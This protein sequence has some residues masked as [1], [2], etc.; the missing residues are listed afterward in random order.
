MVGCQ[1]LVQAVHCSV[2]TRQGCHH[3]WPHCVLLSC[4]GIAV[5]SVIGLSTCWTVMAAYYI[6]YAVYGS[7]MLMLL[8]VLCECIPCYCNITFIVDVIIGLLPTMHTG[9]CKQNW[10]YDLH[11]CSMV[12]E[13]LQYTLS[14]PH[15]TVYDVGENCNCILH[16]SFSTL[17]KDCI[18]QYTCIV[19]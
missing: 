13:P 14:L 6:K 18:F 4:R 2:R 11:I 3:S 15:S 10:L 17:Q 1:G 9:A 5:D 19:H 8:S 12:Q 7:D 16:I